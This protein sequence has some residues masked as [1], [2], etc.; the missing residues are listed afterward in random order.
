MY[1]LIMRVLGIFLVIIFSISANVA[2]AQEENIQADLSVDEAYNHMIFLV[3]EVGER[4]AG[5]K[6][7]EKGR[8]H[9]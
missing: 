7:I 9:S 8:F 5:T 3:E 4:L 6:S 1:R 2:Q